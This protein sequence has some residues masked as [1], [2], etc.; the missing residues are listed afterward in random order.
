MIDLRL[1]KSLR[2]QHRENDESPLDLK[3]D[4]RERSTLTPNVEKK[5][6]RALIDSYGKPSS[7]KTRPSEH[8]QKSLKVWE[9]NLWILNTPT[10]FSSFICR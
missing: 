9:Q 10:D 4:G 1:P 8:K 2:S 7:T 3:L 6:P 5:T